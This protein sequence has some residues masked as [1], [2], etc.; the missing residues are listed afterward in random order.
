QPL[1]LTGLDVDSDVTVADGQAMGRSG[2]APLIV[3][4]QTGKGRAVLLNY[5]FGAAYRVRTQ[6][7][8]L[9]QW[10]A[11][12]GVLALAKVAPQVTVTTDQ[13]G[14]PPQAA[15]TPPGDPL[16]QLET[17]RFEDGPVYYLAFLKYR[18][19]ATEPLTTATVTTGEA[20]H[21]YDMRTG[22]Y[23][24]NV[25]AWDAEF[26]PARAKLYARLPYEVKDVKAAVRLAAPTAGAQTEGPV[27]NCSIELTA[28]AGTPGKHWIEL[29]VLGPDGQPRPCYARNVPLAN[30]K[31]ISAIPLALNDPPGQW[32]LVA[33]DSISHKT[34]TATFKL[35]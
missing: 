19:G 25:A 16:R 15:G 12:R 17:V 21:T 6:P 4:K 10:A 8:A 26:T 35:P 31:A 29:Q 5:A 30:G 14:V 22:Q 32:K 13:G 1:E 11:L 7:T 27:A 9:P 18:I 34:A 20:R 28:S 2:E 33:R 3:I 24:G 23:L